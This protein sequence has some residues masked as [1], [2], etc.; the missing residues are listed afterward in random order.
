MI[1]R[2]LRDAQGGVTQA[3]RLLGF[4]HYQSFIAL[5]NNR[6]RELLPARTPAVPRRRSIIR[7][8]DIRNSPRRGRGKKTRP[9]RVLHAEADR[10]LAD[11][12]DVALVARG[13][14]VDLCLDGAA[15]LRRVAGRA[16]YDLLLVGDRLPG[17]GGMEVVRRARQLAHR[18]RTP[19]VML[20]AGECGR[21]AWG[22]GVDAFLKKPDEV[23][24]VAGTVVRLLRLKR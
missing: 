4:T 3:S 7:R 17:A 8:E 2:A 10:A 5:L 16:P 22:A 18:R 14:E 11:R 19:I 15:A 24:A 13:W 12:V 21:E 23:V 6:Y 9:V 1:E 20:G